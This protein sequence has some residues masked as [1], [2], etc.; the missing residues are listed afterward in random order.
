MSIDSAK[1]YSFMQ[2]VLQ[3]I[4]LGGMERVVYLLCNLTPTPVSQTSHHGKLVALTSKLY[5]VVL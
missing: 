4:T 1:M 5:Y 2:V 3:K